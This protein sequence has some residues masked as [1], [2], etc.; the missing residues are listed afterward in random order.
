MEIPFEE[1][2]ARDLAP[3]PKS[4]PITSS[5]KKSSLQQ[6]KIEFQESASKYA[7]LRKQ[8]ADGAED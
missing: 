7:V 5:E 3:T 2:S 1:G 8:S 6:Q 4:N